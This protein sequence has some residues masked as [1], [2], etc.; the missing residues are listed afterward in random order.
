MVR[1]IADVFKKG[2]F[3][4]AAA[5]QIWRT[6]ICASLS[7]ESDLNVTAFA[8]EN[9][10]EIYW[11]AREYFGSVTPV[12]KEPTSK[13]VLGDVIDGKVEV[14]VLPPPDDSHEGSWWPRL[15]EGLKVFACVPFVLNKGEEI[16]AYA[17]AKLEPEPTGNDIT[18]LCIETDMDVS[19]NRLK[20]TFDKL[21]LDVHWLAV[22]SF[23]SSHR[24]HL[25]EMKGFVT[26]KDKPMLAFKEEIGASVL[27]IRELGAYA[28]PIIL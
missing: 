14:G 16:K 24:T 28:A 13:R 19:Q 27:A 6:I 2:E 23:R 12:T 1:R 10:H 21:G 9:Q 15:P 4:P 18:L 3:P 8:P 5:A 7:L 25:V 22:E 17:V 20:T 11:L 26:A